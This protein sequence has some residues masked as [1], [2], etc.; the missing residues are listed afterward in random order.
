MKVVS[1]LRLLCENC[2]IVRR[3]KKLYMRCTTSPRHKRRQGF[4]TLNYLAQNTENVSA[5]TRTYDGY[6]LDTPELL[7]QQADEPKCSN[8]CGPIRQK[9]VT[10][11]MSIKAK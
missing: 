7:Q 1:A 10:L 11:D 2:Y 4:G 9:P 3:G 6:S 5:T 8:C